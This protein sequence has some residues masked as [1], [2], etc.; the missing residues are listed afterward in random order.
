MAMRSPM[1]GQ[2]SVAWRG[3]R[4]R[5]WHLHLHASGQLQ[6]Q[7]TALP[8][9]SATARAAR[10]P[11]LWPSPSCR[12]T[13]RRQLRARP[14]PPMKI[15][16][17]PAPCRQRQISMAMPSPTAKAATLR[18]A[19]WW[20]MP[21]AP[22]PTRRPPTTT[23]PTAL[24]TRS[25]TAKAAAIPTRWRSRSAR[26]TMHRRRWIRSSSPMKTL[27]K[28]G[29]LPVATD[30]DG[31]T[32][33]YSKASNPAHG[34][35]VVNADGTYTYTPAA[36]Y[37]GPTALPIR[38]AMATV[39]RTPIRWPSRSTLRRLPPTTPSSRTKIR[40]RPAPCRWQKMPT[41]MPLPM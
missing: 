34:T 30:V 6:W 40:S 13:M 8:I 20:S 25:M 4:Q 27:T 26:S 33:T 22:T 21:T 35:L 39:G 7:P 18:T 29:S 19:P 31:D 12:S 17:R 1:Q 2:R 37:H 15:R 14:S 41:A 32:V 38:S 16:S 5:Q 23:A 11:T 28:T 36:N 9:P 10:T 24:P 3:D